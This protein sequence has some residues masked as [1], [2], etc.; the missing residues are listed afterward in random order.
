[1]Q[2]WVLRC[3]IVLLFVVM[4]V[5]FTTLDKDVPMD[6]KGEPLQGWG[7]LMAKIDAYRSIGALV[8]FGIVSAL[9]LWATGVFADAESDLSKTFEFMIFIIGSVAAVMS[10]VTKRIREVEQYLMGVI[11]EEL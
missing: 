2:Y 8:A 11:M 1:M 10:H 5:W 7:R 6:S 3:P 4:L 9:I